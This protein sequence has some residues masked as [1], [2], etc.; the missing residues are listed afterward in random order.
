MR[1]P[2]LGR[3]RAIDFNV[4]PMIDVVFLLIIFFLVSSHL[5]SQETRMD[6]L[7]PD[8][9]S[10]LK[11]SEDLG[12]W[13]TINVTSD[14][15]T[16]LGGQAASVADITKR[17]AVERESASEELQVRIRADRSVPYGKVTP[18]LAAC[19]E[20]QVWDVAFAVEDNKN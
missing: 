6:L 3:D 19:V 18:L 4:T 20:A 7:L 5:S 15:Q 11:A 9:Q 10:Q 1:K 2:C 13:V 12:H 16:Y 17:L 14:G 8:A